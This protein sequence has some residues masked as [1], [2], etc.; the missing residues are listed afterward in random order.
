MSRLQEVYARLSEFIEEEKVFGPCKGLDDLFA[1]YMI[2]T[3]DEI[4]HGPPP[5]LS[6]VWPN[7]EITITL[8]RDKEEVYTFGG[9]RKRRGMP[10]VY[11]ATDSDQWYMEREG[12][13]PRER[14]TL[15]PYEGQLIYRFLYE[16]H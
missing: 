10:L 3:A 16:S 12:L 7:G 5:R 13:E 2:R 4:R 15:T 14:V 6:Q 1:S 8:M 11:K 9:P